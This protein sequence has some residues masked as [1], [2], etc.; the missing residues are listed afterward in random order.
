M[1]DT[2]STENQ[3]TKPSICIF[4]GLPKL[5]SDQTYFR[6]LPCFP[7]FDEARDFK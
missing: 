1:E 5:I 3:G 7:W 6:V 4:G 2:E